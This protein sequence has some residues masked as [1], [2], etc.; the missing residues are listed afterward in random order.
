MIVEGNT[1]V[2]AHASGDKPSTTSWGFRSD[3]RRLAVTMTLCS[4]TRR[5]WPVYCSWPRE[6]RRFAPAG[7]EFR[8]ARYRRAPPRSFGLRIRRRLDLRPPLAI[9]CLGRICP[10]DGERGGKRHANINLNE[11]HGKL[12]GLLSE[13]MR[14][15]EYVDWS[16]DWWK[17]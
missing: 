8:P 16:V 14:F 5:W 2:P 13:W 17:L 7:T 11:R 3:R 12:V 1:L 15:A 4:A 10:L 9:C 6:L